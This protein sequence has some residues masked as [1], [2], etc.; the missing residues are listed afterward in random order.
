MRHCQCLLLHFVAQFPSPARTTPPP[1]QLR[2][3]FLEIA[4]LWIPKTN[5]LYNSLLSFSYSNTKQRQLSIL[6]VNS[7]KTNNIQVL[8][9]QVLCMCA[10]K[11]QDPQIPSK[12]IPELPQKIFG[13]T[14][15]ERKISTW[16]TR[17]G[18]VSRDWNLN[19][20]I[21][22]S[23][24]SWCSLGRCWFLKGP[25]IRALQPQIEL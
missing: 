6:I 5:I 23:N 3:D 25:V 7:Q 4:F 14:S 22:I 24:R 11:S 8:N 9:S 13:R 16:Q 19:Y 20:E 18:L 12:W 2:L 21:I 1:S 17:T 15:W 10:N